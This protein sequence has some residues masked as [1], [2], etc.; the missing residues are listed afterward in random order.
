MSHSHFTWA[1]GA[2]SVVWRGP[3]DS[4]AFLAVRRLCAAMLPSRNC[5]AGMHV[6][7]SEA[8]CLIISG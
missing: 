2:V 8:F 3:C 7:S 6:K 5:L 1:C 4:F